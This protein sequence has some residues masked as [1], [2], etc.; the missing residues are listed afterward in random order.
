MKDSKLELTPSVRRRVE[1]WRMAEMELSVGE[2]RIE[3]VA[4]EPPGPVGLGG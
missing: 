4:V 1:L 3:R 2:R